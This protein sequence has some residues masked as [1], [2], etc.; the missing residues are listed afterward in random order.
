MTTTLPRSLRFL[1][2]DKILELHERWGAERQLENRQAVEFGLTKDGGAFSILLTPEQ[3][4][5]LRKP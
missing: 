4:E 5:K 2:G 1:H 3:F